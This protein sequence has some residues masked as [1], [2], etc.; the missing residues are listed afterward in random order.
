MKA[1]LI[2]AWRDDV[3]AYVLYSYPD[4]MRDKVDGQDLMNLYN[5]HRFRSTE[6]NFQIMKRP[7]FN[8][9]SFYSG[10]YQSNYIGK[11]NYCVTLLLDDEDNPNEYEKVLIKVTNNLLSAMDSV[12]DFD[13]DAMM[14]DTFNK[15]DVKDFD[16]IKVSRTEV[17]E[18][19]PAP[20]KSLATTSSAILSDEEKIFADLMESDELN[21]NIAGSGS[22][23]DAFEKAGAG[24][25]FS[26]EAANP[27]GGGASA[28]TNRDIYAENPFDDAQKPSFEAAFKIDEAIGKTMF[29]QKK[30]TAAE[31][32]EKL[33]SLEN[34]RPPKP[35]EGDKE[36]QFKY[37]ETLVGFLEEKVKI[38]GTLANQVKDLQKTD[39]EKD[40]LIGKLLLLLKQ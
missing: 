8:A 1:L 28:T 2:L 5:A 24:D 18:E 21:V 26:G 33:D 37:L 19:G 29:Q 32:V 31:I 40:Q 7:G 39:E 15:L 34:S 16:G 10:G 9:A 3:G 12:D 25:P 23:L 17:I 27:F 20:K 22:D 30:T 6:K 38:L 14:M 4:S 35:S 11:P 36:A 13:F